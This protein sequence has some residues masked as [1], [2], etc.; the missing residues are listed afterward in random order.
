V[1]SMGRGQGS[2]G[3]PDRGL[4]GNSHHSIDPRQRD[5]WRPSVTARRA[6]EAGRTASSSETGEC[7]RVCSLADWLPGVSLACRLGMRRPIQTRSF[8]QADPETVWA[9]V[10]TVQGVNDELWPLL[11]M[12][13]PRSV[14]KHGLE[15]VTVGERICRSWVLL[16]G[17]LP[18]DYDDITLERL[19]PPRS[20]LERSKML[21]QRAWE[22]HRSIEHAP[23]GAVVTDR[24]RYEPRLPVP[25]VVLRPLYKAIFEHRHRRLRK[26]FRA[27][28]GQGTGDYQGR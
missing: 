9:R 7:R 16:F 24:I 19:E 14:Q 11:R 18:V 10:T 17:V 13:A 4:R 6:S 12:T 8:L 27:G 22:H 1:A 3:R 15:N 21:S 28:A 5:H 2:T 25:D 26:H 20:F 23:G